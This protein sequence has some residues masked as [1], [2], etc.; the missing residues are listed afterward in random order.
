MLVVALI[1]KGNKQPIYRNSFI[2]H[3][4]LVTLAE[5]C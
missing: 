3:R 5:G 4:S 2:S 1:S